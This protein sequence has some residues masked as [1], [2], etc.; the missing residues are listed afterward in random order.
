MK[1]RSFLKNTAGAA[2]TL[3]FALQ[4]VRLSALPRSAFFGS[5]AKD[6]DR[7]LS[8]STVEMTG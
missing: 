6:T 7:V 8:A 4:G 5:M 2:V 1:R 3:P